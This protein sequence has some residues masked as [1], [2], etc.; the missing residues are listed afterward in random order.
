MDEF[1]VRDAK[2]VDLSRENSTEPYFYDDCFQESNRKNVK[3]SLVFRKDKHFSLFVVVPANQ[4]KE[5]E[6]S[7][8]EATAPAPVGLV[9]RQCQRL[10]PQPILA[11]SSLS[12]SIR[13][14]FTTLLA[15]VTSS[16]PEPQDLSH[17]HSSNTHRRL[18]DTDSSTTSSGLPAVTEHA[19]TLPRS[20][21][22]TRTSESSSLPVTSNFKVRVHITSI[23]SIH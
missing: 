15:P 4:W 12:E 16:N 14:T 19:S 21:P 11:S 2:W 22:Q 17:S 18:F 7:Q 1:V 10:R 20:V 3:G 5:F 6:D 9:I 13:S 23:K 8:L